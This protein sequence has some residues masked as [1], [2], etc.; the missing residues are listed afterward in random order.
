[1]YK[2]TGLLLLPVAL[3]F[4]ISCKN[5]E[6]KFSILPSSKTHITFENNLEKKKAFNILY[7]LYYYNG[8]G[9]AAGDINN[10]GLTDIYFAANSKGRNK[11]YLNKGNFQFEDIT[12]KAKVQGTSDWC[13]GVTMT[14][15][16]GDGF[17][18]I[19]VS[20]IGGTKWTNGHNELFINNGDGTFTESS[21]Q[22]GLDFSGYTTQAAF[23]DYDHDGDLDC[24][25]LNQ[26]LDP[27]GNIVDTSLRKKFDAKAGDRLLR[28]DLSTTGRFTDVSKDAGINQSSLGYGLGISVADINN[29]GWEDIYI[30]NDFHENDY[31]YVNQGNGTFVEEGAIHFNHYSRA[32]MGND[33]ADFNNDGQMDIATVDM[34]PPD[35]KNLKTYGSDENIDI[36]KF[37]IL[38]HGYQSQVSRNCL[39]M[40][41]A[42]GTSF[43]DVALIAGISATDWS[44]TPLFADFDNDGNKDLFVSS[45]IVKRPVDLDYVKFIS[46]MYVKQ[47]L[48]KTDKYDDV[49]LERMPEGALHPFLFKGNGNMRF[50]DVSEDWGLSDL[51]G[52]YNGAA[53][54]DLN[55]DGNLDIIINVLNGPALILKNNSKNTNQI[56]ISFKGMDQNKFGVGVKVYLYAGGKMQL[57]QMMPTRGFMSSSE[58]RLHFGLDSNSVADSAVIIWPSQKYQVLKNVPA[59]VPLVVEEINA[60]GFFDIK[61]YS[62]QPSYFTDITKNINLKWRHVENN[63]NDFGIQYLLPHMEST[64]GPKIAVADV[65][66][67]GLDDFY[68]CGA[69]NQAGA[70]M[71]QNSDGT[72]RAS[73]TAEFL[74][75]AV[76][77]E[78][79][80]TFFDANNDGYPD[81][82]VVA[83]GNE[84]PQNVHSL[85]DRLYLNDGKGHFKKSPNAI[86]QQYENKTCI[87]VADVDRDG[88]MDVF[89]GNMGAINAYG[90]VKPSF[91]YF[92]NGKGVF[93]FDYKKA[94]FD[95]LGIVT[96]AAFADINND[97][98]PDLIVAGE[99]MQVKIFMN[100]KGRFVQSEIPAS[101]GLW[102]SLY[103]TDINNDG[104]VDIIAGNWGYNT[105]LWSGKISPLK[106][107]VKD[108]DRNGSTE[109]ILCYTLP[110]GKE[111]TFLAKDELERR[112]PVLK[113]AYPTYGEVAGKTVDYIFYDLFKD[114]KE[115]KAEILGS[116]CF[117]NDGKGNFKRV[118]LPDELQLSPI[119]SFTKMSDTSFMAV[120]NF[121]GV[122]PYEGRYDALYPSQFCYD[123]STGRIRYEHSIFSA[124]GEFR[125]IKHLKISGGNSILALARN[126]DGLLFYKQSNN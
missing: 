101:S 77:E 38:G 125:D 46:D 30:G 27:V 22:F 17:L 54:A 51:H 87:A 68:V 121:Y 95:S 35:E 12:E 55:N 41:N 2:G 118:D 76:T 72:F 58:P 15:I 11:L 53:Y 52:Y 66:R 20:A 120:G 122:M 65:N 70:M 106:M 8:A 108:F 113:K 21:K 13:T 67:D 75:N 16:N 116:C 92:N 5:K 45:G 81:L 44:W 94:R 82:W 50:E 33:V 105:K 119:F 23:F 107:Y 61:R 83:G 115:Y 85:E 96:S 111:Y 102:Q 69:K 3:C 88:D 9:V 93:D 56:T 31:Y 110:D 1:M 64:R 39:Q 59:N 34:L 84:Y 90:N 10:D 47:T 91:L 4:C 6:R 74:I 78:V 32:S 123:K 42:N 117:I 89:I 62:N 126:N 124:S 26:S 48:D 100:N 49:A 36:Y 109:Q 28:N 79:D 112:L 18:D 40:N 25:I 29:D 104:N 57:Q 80:A 98:W 97:G 7:Y 24:Y 99:F 60:A 43:S 37:K 19:Y 86:N 71:I 63:F 73:D 103:L 114:Y 14:D